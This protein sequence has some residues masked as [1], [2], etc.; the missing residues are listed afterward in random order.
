MNRSLF[1]WI[2]PPNHVDKANW[3]S[4]I[5]RKNNCLGYGIV[6]CDSN[7]DIVATLYSNEDFSNSPII[8]DIKVLW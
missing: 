2:R 3:C 4:V 7:G 5:D 1:N 6:V 8:A